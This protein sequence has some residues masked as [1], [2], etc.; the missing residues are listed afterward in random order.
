[1][2]YF[3]CEYSS[4]LHA[5]IFCRCF[6][7]TKP[8]GTSDDLQHGRKYHFEWTFYFSPRILRSSDPAMESS[9]GSSSSSKSE[10]NDMPRYLRDMSFTRILRTPT[11]G[12]SFTRILRWDNRICSS[13]NN[14]ITTVQYLMNVKANS[15][16]KGDLAMQTLA[17]EPQKID[18]SLHRPLT[19][20]S[21][22]LWRF[23]KKFA[24]R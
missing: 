13:G 19:W 24:S 3:N 2:L 1:M 5:L 22:K 18:R 14:I 9:E 23:T 10:D 12:S 16:L 11:S 6:F 4:V 21:D 15:L 20:W 7:L 17:L 8:K